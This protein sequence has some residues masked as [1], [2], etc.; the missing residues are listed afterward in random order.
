VPKVHPWVSYAVTAPMQEAVACALE[1]A[2]GL[3]DYY[4]ALSAKSGSGWACK[5]PRGRSRRTMGTGSGL[6]K[7]P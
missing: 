4:E 2:D 5:R 6:L 7:V 3:D 1:G